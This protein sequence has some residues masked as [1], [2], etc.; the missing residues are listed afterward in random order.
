MPRNKKTGD[1]LDFKKLAERSDGVDRIAC[2]R[3]DVD[4]L[5]LIF[6][7][8]LNVPSPDHNNIL[9]FM[10]LS[11]SLALFFDGYVSNVLLKE[12]RFADVYLIYSGS[13]ICL[14]GPWSLMADLAIAINSEF[15]RFVASNPNLTISAGVQIAHHDYPLHRLVAEAGNRLDAAKELKLT[16]DGRELVK[17]AITFFDVA[18]NWADFENQVMKISYNLAE[19]IEEK[20]PRGFLHGLAVTANEFRRQAFE[21]RAGVVANR[22]SYDDAVFKN[23]KIWRLANFLRK[24]RPKGEDVADKFE[25]AVRWINSA[26][27]QNKKALA[28]LDV[29]VRWAEY[30][31]RKE[32]KNNER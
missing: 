13:D 15:D 7:K 16:V 10:A 26:P 21:G 24:R 11:R 20:I 1:I 14:V 12:E 6:Q 27:V 32:R 18:F 8:G 5:G 25:A 23:I 22:F 30:L 17:N 28:Y 2:G 19:L 4:N 3:L 31:T 9:R 29:P